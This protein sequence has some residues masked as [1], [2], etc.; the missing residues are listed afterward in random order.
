MDSAKLAALRGARDERIKRRQ[1]ARDPD[2]AV[3][4]SSSRQSSSSRPRS[5]GRASVT[6][7]EPP[8]ISEGAVSEGEQPNPHLDL[9]NDSGDGEHILVSSDEEQ[10]EESAITNSPSVQALSRLAEAQNDLVSSI[11]SELSAAQDTRHSAPK[12]SQQENGASADEALLSDSRGHAPAPLSDEAQAAQAR[13][14]EQIKARL[15]VAET[16]HRHTVRALEEERHKALVI[17]RS[18]H[19][20]RSPQAQRAASRARF[21]KAANSITP[22]TLPSTLTA[23]RAPRLMANPDSKAQK[24]L[25][26]MVVTT[27]ASEH[28]TLTLDKFF[29]KATLSER[30]ALDDNR[31]S[32]LQ[33]ASTAIAAGLKTVK[34]RRPAKIERKFSGRFDKEEREAIRRS[35]RI[36]AEEAS[37][38]SVQGRQVNR[39]GYEEDDFCVDDS[40]KD[41]VSEEESSDDDGSCT[42]L[43]SELELS[44]DE[45]DFEADARTAAI[46][47]AFETAKAKSKSGP[48][49]LC[50]CSAEELHRH[51]L[52]EITIKRPTSRSHVVELILNSWL[53]SD[54]ATVKLKQIEEFLRLLSI[55]P[56]DYALS[57][58]YAL[59]KR[60]RPVSNSFYKLLFRCISNY[61]PEHIPV[62]G[63][64]HRDVWEREKKE[65]TVTPATPTLQPYAANPERSAGLERR[66][67]STRAPQL[68]DIHNIRD[69]TGNFYN[70]YK[71]YD[72]DWRGF[73]HKS[74]F[75]C[76]TPNQAAEFV[77]LCRMPE[78]KVAA[79]PTEEFMELWR[80]K[81]GFRSSAA[82]VKALESVSFSGPYLTPSSWS[83][84]HQRFAAVLLQA[85]SPHHPPGKTLAKL[86]MNNCGVQYLATDVL[87]FEPGS[88]TAARD[89]VLDRINDGGFLQSPELQQ[90]VSSAESAQ[91]RRTEANQRPLDSTVRLD[92]P[93]HDGRPSRPDAQRHNDDKFRRRDDRPHDQAKQT[94]R[95]L[96]RQQDTGKVQ[97]LAPAPATPNVVCTRCGRPGHTINECVAKHDASRALLPPVDDATYERRKAAALA[98]AKKRLQGVHALRDERHSSDTEDIDGEAVSILQHDCDHSDGDGSSVCFLRPCHVDDPHALR[99]SSDADNIHCDD[100]TLMQH[101]ADQ[102]FVSDDCEGGYY[103]EF[104][105]PGD[106]CPAHFQY[107]LVV[108]SFHDLQARSFD[109]A[110]KANPS[111]YSDLAPG[112]SVLIDW[113][114]D[115]PPLPTLPTK[116]GPYRVVDSRRNYVVLQH[117]SYPPPQDQRYIVNWSKNARVYRYIDD[118]APQRSS[119]DPSA[120]QTPTGAPGRMIDCVLSHQPKPN[121]PSAGRKHVVNQQYKC[122]LYGTQLSARGQADFVRTFNYAEIAHTFSFDCYVQAQRD[123]VGHVP[124][125]HMPDSWS[126]HCVPKSDQPSHPPLPLHE[127]SFPPDREGSEAEGDGD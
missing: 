2:A 93:R 52:T 88:H 28:P 10:S 74:I 116:Q 92:G 120:S 122:R 68:S 113:P 50:S 115:Q 14:L 105:E 55:T 112:Q 56:L 91:R 124:V 85:P 42:T 126:P 30:L 118:E 47:A 123:L 103:V 36:T 96:D 40:F 33:T 94:P 101:Y 53:R 127:Q 46:H 61:L 35:D 64:A 59:A 45:E 70:A 11:Q 114:R 22:R 16:V 75:E 84:Y 87:A 3:S 63:R 12:L 21:N 18:L 67:P 31:F 69:A 78:D 108:N 37:P 125:A 98:I 73:D 15:S 79:L 1:T 95:P 5:G 24:A 71:A 62:F 110:S 8:A 72:R 119:L 23:S 107:Q 43:D 7:S 86:F 117:W 9:G 77:S 109:A 82:V 58:Y 25:K 29:R 26:T 102:S 90:A 20:E 83:L 41:L 6:N 13:A 57:I 65:A 106:F 51:R 48:F 4:A 81:C 97:T 17:F 49:L 32:A 76:M 27:A 54:I 111:A 66:K 100:S 104:E 38:D 89:L 34:S 80:E 44:S 60:I 121:I 19:P 99:H 39:D